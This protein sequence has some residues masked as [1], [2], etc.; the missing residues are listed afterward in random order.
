MAS[1]D[2]LARRITSANQQLKAARRDGSA[3]D[4]TTW[5]ERLDGLLD[6]LSAEIKQQVKEGSAT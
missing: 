2:N 6:E 5:R 4:I 3:R 1:T